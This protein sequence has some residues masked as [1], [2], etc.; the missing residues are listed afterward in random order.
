MPGHSMRCLGSACGRGVAW[1]AFGAA[2]DGA[3]VVVV[4]FMPGHAWVEVC[5]ASPAVSEAGVNLAFVVGSDLLVSVVIA[6]LA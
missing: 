4:A 1:H 3:V 2:I 5:A 6:T